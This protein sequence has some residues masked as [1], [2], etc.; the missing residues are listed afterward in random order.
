MQ[1]YTVQNYVLC[2]EGD[3]M[4]TLCIYGTINKRESIYIFDSLRR[5]NKDRILPHFMWYWI[6]YCKYQIGV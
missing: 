2:S 5:V 6:P 3:S 4:Y 1:H